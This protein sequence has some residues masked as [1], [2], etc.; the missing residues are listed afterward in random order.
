MNPVLKAELDGIDFGVVETT[1][2]ILAGYFETYVHF[3]SKRYTLSRSELNVFHLPAFEFK[4]KDDITTENVNGVSVPLT[5]SD[6]LALGTKFLDAVLYMHLGSALRPP[7]KDIMQPKGINKNVSL[8]TFSNHT[9]IARYMFFYY[10]YI[11]TRARAPE[12]DASGE[13]QKVP[14]F[15]NGVLSISASASEV[16]SYLAS[17]DLN[18]L[19][20]AWVRQI[21]IKGIGQEALSRFG[22]GVA[23]YR[24]AQPF[25]L[26]EPDGP[27][28]AKYANAILVAK[29]FTSAPAC[30]DFHPATRNP[31]I[32]NKYGNINKNLGNLLLKVY[33]K[34]TLQIMSD[35]R[36]IFQV[37]IEEPNYT[38][39]ER[40]TAQD[41]YSSSAPIFPTS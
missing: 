21:R 11:L 9:T 32:L 19:D 22:L 13:V 18:N 34:E 33:K 8:P 1:P 35:A 15:L 23:G 17:F 30:W 29:S 2:E 7:T 16:A 6:H 27:D 4:G 25:K 41:I 39:Y 24:L 26:R 3:G 40:W 37:P 20:P 31:N 38:N 10:F 28:R 5:L 14:R 36:I 12:R